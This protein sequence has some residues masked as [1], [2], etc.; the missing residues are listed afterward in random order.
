MTPAR[1]EV[2]DLAPEDRR[3]GFTFGLWDTFTQ[4]FVVGGGYF[5]QRKVAETQARLY[6]AAYERTL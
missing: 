3:D 4:S 6:N 1:Y 5:K 2:R